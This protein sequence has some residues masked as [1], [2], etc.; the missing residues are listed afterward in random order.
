MAIRAQDQLTLVDLTD[1]YAV[2]LEKYAHIFDG[3]SSNAL[4][5]STTCKVT[6]MC[7]PDVVPCSVNLANV[8]AP[9]GV[10]VTK[11]SNA[12]TPTLTITVSTSFA[13][14]GVVKVP[15]TIGGDIEITQYVSVSFAK[16][17]AMGMSST[18]AGLKNE[19]YMIP[20]NSSGQTLA[21]T[22][23]AVDFFGYVGATRTA[24][25][26]VVGTLPSGITVGT[27][28]AGTSGADGVLTFSV[29]AGSNLG[30]GSAGNIPVTLTCNSIPLVKQFSW[31]KAQAGV[32]GSNAVTVDIV[33][34]GGLIFKNMSVATT[35][36]AKVYVGGVE[37]TGGA[38]TALGTVKWYKGGVYQ[39]GKDGVTL[40]VAAGDVDNSATYDARL[41]Y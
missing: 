29:A 41:E 34:S 4:A 28:T 39:T 11:D 9:T 18:I 5:G 6:A 8:T 31:S 33:S 38:L 1:G 23:I 20:C 15:V 3:N 40:I 2:Y 14:P 30:G 12:T 27:N 17:G 35:L 7:G 16:T 32:D 13:T 22:T 10:T 19:A 21:A 36:T 26:A 24:V 37:V 25:T